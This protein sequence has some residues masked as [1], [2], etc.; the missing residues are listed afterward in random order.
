MGGR[1][2]SRWFEERARERE[3]HQRDRVLNKEGQAVRVR[4]FETRENGGR[5]F[6]GD[7]SSGYYT[8][9]LLINTQ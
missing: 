7:W 8:F 9:S 1:V 3:K 4:Q 5:G 2:G 6:S